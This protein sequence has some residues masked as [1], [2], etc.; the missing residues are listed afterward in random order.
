MFLYMGQ[1]VA[2][3]GN[4]DFLLLLKSSGSL[5]IFNPNTPES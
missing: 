3:A 4:M 5:D 1:K 2:W